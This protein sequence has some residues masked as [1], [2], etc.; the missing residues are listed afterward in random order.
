MRVFSSG[1]GV[2]RRIR[3]KDSA[4]QGRA[5]LHRYAIP[6]ERAVAVQLAFDYEASDDCDASCGT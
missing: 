4:V 1:W 3:G 6:L 5:Y 2:D